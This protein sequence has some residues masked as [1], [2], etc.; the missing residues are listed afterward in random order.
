MD[1]DG[2]D[3]VNWAAFKSYFSQAVPGVFNAIDLNAE[4]GCF[5]GPNETLSAIKYINEICI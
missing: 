4:K 1:P 5:G 2:N 3:L